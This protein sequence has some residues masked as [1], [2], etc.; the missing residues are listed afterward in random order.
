[1][2]SAWFA[3]FVQDFA[4]AIPDTH[5]LMIYKVWQ[6]LHPPIRH[7]I[8]PNHTS[9][10]SFCDALRNLVHGVETVPTALPIPWH[11]RPLAFHIPYQVGDTPSTSGL[12]VK[13]TRHMPELF[14]GRDPDPSN[15]KEH[16]KARSVSPANGNISDS[17]DEDIDTAVA[18]ENEDEIEEAEE[19]ATQPQAHGTRTDLSRYFWPRYALPVLCEE[20]L[21]AAEA[22]ASSG[23]QLLGL[24]YDARKTIM[25]LGT[26]F[27]EF[28]PLLHTSPQIYT[29][30]QWN[31]IIQVPQ[32]HRGFKIGYALQF[33]THT[34]CW[35]TFDNNFRLHWR[36]PS[37]HAKVYEDTHVPDPIHDYPAWCLYTVEWLK[38]AKMAKQLTLL[39]A[40]SELSVTTL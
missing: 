34:L 11:R 37:E 40:L 26:V 2:Y 25:N 7:Q 16:S 6:G 19:P 3:M 13:L 36:T 35:T 1:M 14:R 9:W 4:D 24:V 17:E 39:E 21:T 8:S 18:L 22:M 20:A 33:L 10:D 30:K 27:V 29:R 32:G 28:E 31:G 23:M 15:H 5:G 38:Y 12:V